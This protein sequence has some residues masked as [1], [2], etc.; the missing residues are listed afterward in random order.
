MRLLSRRNDG[1][2]RHIH[3]TILVIG[4]MIF[5][6]EFS[7]AGVSGTGDRTL[8]EIWS[9]AGRLTCIAHYA[10][11]VAV[12]IGHGV[13]VA[14]RQEQTD[15]GQTSRGGFERREDAPPERLT[16]ERYVHRATRLGYP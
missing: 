16:R 11:F 13:L 10:V 5:L 6:R 14:K 9:L 7:H 12:V 8:L 1:M 3:F 4:S 15:A 2:R